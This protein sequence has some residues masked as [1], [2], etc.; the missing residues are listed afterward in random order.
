MDKLTH[1]GLI[2]ASKRQLMAFHNKLKQ[3]RVE[4]NWTQ[5]QLAEKL[6][7]QQKQ[8]SSYERGA[9]KPSTEILI[10]IA[11]TFEVSLDYLVFEI[12]G[13]NA[14]V[15]VKDRELLRAFETIDNFEDTEKRLTKEMLGLVIAKH[16]L[17]ALANA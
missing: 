3:L 14:K 1:L 10:K 6:N 12:K 8:I 13:E 17:R 2:L 5:A 11:E 9:S 7:I 4:Q 16:Q 15:N